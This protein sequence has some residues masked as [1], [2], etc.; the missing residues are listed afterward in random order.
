MLIKTRRDFLKIGLRSVSAL[1]AAG[2]LGQLGTMT[3]LAAGNPNPNYNSYGALVCIFLSGGNDGNNTVVPNDAATYNAYNASRQSLAVPK[4]QLLNIATSSQGNFG[5]Y[6]KMPEMQALYNSGKCA[7]LANV[8]MLVVPVPDKNTYSQWASNGSQLP[9]NLFSHSD[10]ASQWQNTA[11]TG[12]SSSGWGGRLADY[13]SPTQNAGS[14]FPAVVTTGACGPFCTGQSTLPTV[15]PFSGPVQVTGNGSD[16]ARIQGFNQ[17][18]TFDNGLQLVQAGNSIVNRGATYVNLL[19]NQLKSAPKLNTVFPVGP[20]GSPN[21]LADQLKMVAQIIGVHAGLS[22]NKQIFFVN[23]G[24]F[25]THGGQ[26]ASQDLL[27]LE[28]SQAIN[29]FYNATVELGVANQVTTFTSSEFGRTLMVNSSGGTD[30][31]WGSHHFIVGGAVKGG[32][33]YGTYPALQLNSPLDVNGR[34]SMIPSTAVEQYGAT[35]AQWFGVDP[36]PA[37]MSQIFQNVGNFPTANLG[38]MG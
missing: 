11:P 23:F 7:I 8:G 28:L 21:P 34:G 4:S 6:P 12:I 20:D 18:L 30:H 29:A 5:L 13:Y 9:V 24:G 35:L 33:M 10:Q 19:T 25:D 27:L 36:S 2:A 32:D 22:L 38:F 15:V 14:Q 31:A 17:L 37:V 26:A 3:A 16:Q 1:G